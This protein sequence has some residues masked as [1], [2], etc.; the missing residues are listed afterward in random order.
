MENLIFSI[1]VVLPI[2]SLMILGAFLRKIKL[3]DKEF[4]KKANDFAFKVLLPILLFNNIYKSKISEIVNM[5]LIIFAILINVVIVG[6]LFITVPKF[7]KE[8]RDRSIVIQGLYRTNFVLFGVP[9]SKNIFGASSLGA[10][11]TLTAIIIPLFNFF[12]VFIL[13][14]FSCDKS[15]YKKTFVSLAKNPLIIGSCMGIL[16]SLLN[17]KLPQFAE[18]TIADVAATATPIALI[19]LG[20]DIEIKSLGKNFNLISM[21]TFGKLMIVP[22]IIVISAVLF[23]FR[24]VELG[25]LFCMTAP[26]ISV[27][28]YTMS[29]Q[30]QCNS[31]L[32]GQLVFIT[33]LISPLT[34]FMFIF[35]LKT[36][37]LF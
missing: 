12:A 29:L 3:M 27:S 15:D 18:K 21:V 11:T 17:I 26:P 35:V 4:I 2:F 30:Y 22:A 1:N 10:V 25:A 31:E 20:G 24:G 23:G 16:F 5:K 34:I 28:S 6:I 33:T 32:A 13:D 36:V 8:N 7:I 9:L 37:G 19:V 14:W